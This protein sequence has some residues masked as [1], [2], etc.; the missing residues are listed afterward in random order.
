MWA[1]SGN[2]EAG[3]SVPSPGAILFAIAL[4][5]G[6]CGC[7]RTADR[8]LKQE[9][10]APADGTIIVDILQ[11][12]SPEFY[13]HYA[14]RPSEGTVARIS[15]QRFASRKEE[16][17]P[18]TYM[19]PAGA[20]FACMDRPQAVSPDGAFVATCEGRLNGPNSF[21]VLERGSSRE[22]LRW[23]PP[24]YRGFH[25]FAWS[26]DSKSVALLNTTEYYG[27]SPL[28]LLS[29]LSG[30]PVPH[31]TVYVDLFE[32][33]DW[34]RTEYLVRDEVINAFTRILDWTQ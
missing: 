9:G 15:Q 25:G 22:I 27:K 12:G 6:L 11:S 23:T 33:R 13:W 30:H 14:L 24:Q 4:V 29:G 20:I 31:H 26:P 34:R 2:S 8:E 7:G 32:V 16:S 10:V 19:Q 17:M 5:A 21:I 1:S 28:E 3:R 18:R